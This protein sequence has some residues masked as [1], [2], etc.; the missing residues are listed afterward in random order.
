MIRTRL[1][2]VVRPA[3]DTRFL[4]LIAYLMRA[5]Y[6][7][8]YRSVLRRATRA[9]YRTVYRTMSRIAFPLPFLFTLAI[10]PAS[11]G[12][13][14]NQPLGQVLRG[15][16]VDQTTRT[17]LPGAHVIVVGTVPLLGTTT[18]P[19]GRYVLTGVPLGRQDVSFSYLGYRPLVRPGVL[20]GSAKEV[21]LDVELEE[22]FATG[23]EI[24]V[25][26]DEERGKP[27]NEL[28][29]V[30]ARSFTVEETRRYAGGL[31]DPARTVSAFAGVTTGGLGSNA[32][33]VRGNAP[34][35]VQWRLEGVE[36]PNPNH[37]SGGNVAR[38]RSRHTVQQ[39]FA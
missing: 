12:L 8:V 11:R 22:Q 20:F 6:R 33:I 31:D 15:Q 38:R 39:P 26:P 9:G 34:K 16:V 25:V 7:T 23:E 2:T 36:I 3:L 24:V 13:A 28:A 5:M 30:S 1:R 37:F 32:I 29:M 21:V 4:R 14:Q 27:R 19:D 35:N 18:D 17:P 10:A